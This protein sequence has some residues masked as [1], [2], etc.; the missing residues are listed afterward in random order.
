MTYY[1]Y[2]IV[3]LYIYIYVRN[4][5][6]EFDKKKKEIGKKDEYSTAKNCFDLR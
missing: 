2:I 4:N 5:G 3:Y 6:L 1:L